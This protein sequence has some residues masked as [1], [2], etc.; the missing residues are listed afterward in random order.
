MHDGGE[1]SRRDDI[2]SLGYVM[3]YLLKGLLPW[4]G[5]SS[6]NNYEAVRRLKH[7]I[8]LSELCRGL[9]PAFEKTIAYARAMSFTATPDYR[10]LLSLWSVSAVSAL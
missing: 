5:C 7:T 2:E 3:I 8:P 1:Q 4:Q 10:F 6:Q 9:P